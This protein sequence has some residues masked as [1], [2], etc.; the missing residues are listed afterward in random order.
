MNP[1]VHR[2]VH[3]SPSLVLLRSQMNPIHT[4][5][6]DEK[7]DILKFEMILL[8]FKNFKMKLLRLNYLYIIR[9]EKYKHC[10]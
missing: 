5:A 6:S 10:V 9:K 4:V 2:L 8:K 1:K 7:T 3:N